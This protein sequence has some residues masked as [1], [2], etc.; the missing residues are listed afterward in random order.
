MNPVIGHPT[1]I[2][3]YRSDT[4]VMVK[5]WPIPGVPENAVLSKDDAV[6]VR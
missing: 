1:E 4:I 6:T 3:G 5:F 2:W